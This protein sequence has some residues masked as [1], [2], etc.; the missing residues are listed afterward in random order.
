MLL[1]GVLATVQKENQRQAVK[2]FNYRASLN[3]K[4]FV[5][6][7]TSAVFRALAQKLEV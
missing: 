2:A 7:S 4:F 6:S 3:Q 1:L 5:P